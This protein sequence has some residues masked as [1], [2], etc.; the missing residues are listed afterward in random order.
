MNSSAPLQQLPQIDKELCVIGLINMVPVPKARVTHM[1]TL[2][3]KAEPI[4][5]WRVDRRL[6]L[7]A[8][9]RNRV[10]LNPAPAAVRTRLI[11]DEERQNRHRRQATAD[12]AFDRQ[13]L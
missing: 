7:I 3:A 1:D 10:S 11:V 13:F 4:C 5:R 9:H 2:G 6:V 8:K 12:L